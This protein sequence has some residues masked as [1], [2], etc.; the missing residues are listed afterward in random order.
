MDF[1]RY[2]TCKSDRLYKFARKLPQKREILIVQVE[3]VNIIS[4]ERVELCSVKV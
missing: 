1:K 4:I 3:F 2:E